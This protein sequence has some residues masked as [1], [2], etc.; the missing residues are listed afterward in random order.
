MSVSRKSDPRRARILVVEDDPEAALFTVHVLT[1]RGQYD[2]THTTDARAALR[3]ATSEHWDLV[4]TDIDMPGMNGLDLADALRREVPA[5][6]VAVV[7]AHAPAAMTSATFRRAEVYLEKPLRIEAL[8]DTAAALIGGTIACR[9][10]DR[11][12]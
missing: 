1:H 12:N 10:G 8:L 6:P 5:L 11:D 9:Y 3:L 7:T 4:L 2:V